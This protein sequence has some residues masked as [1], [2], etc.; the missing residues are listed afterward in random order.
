MY[1]E[2][3]FFSPSMILPEPP[4]PLLHVLAPLLQTKTK[5]KAINQNKEPKRQEGEEKEEEEEAAAAAATAN[6]PQK[7]KRGVTPFCF[8]PFM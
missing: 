8:I 1:F 7:D 6:S 4:H 5:T 2:H 3:N